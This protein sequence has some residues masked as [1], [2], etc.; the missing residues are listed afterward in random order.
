M[1]LRK[2]GLCS[3]CSECKGFL[4]AMQLRKGGLCSRCSECKASWLLCNQPIKHMFCNMYHIYA[5]KQSTK[6]NKKK[7][8]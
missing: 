7:N 4:V 2:G 6:E 3:R 8:K 5:K 1:Q